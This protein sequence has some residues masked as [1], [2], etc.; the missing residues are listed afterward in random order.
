M[1][2]PPYRLNGHLIQQT[3]LEPF[4][5]LLGN[6]PTTVVVFLVAVGAE[7]AFANF[8]NQPFFFYGRAKRVMIFHGNLQSERVPVLEQI[9][10]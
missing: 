3:S 4:S 2:I 9:E 8:F 7:F 5:G 10:T 1:G 6:L